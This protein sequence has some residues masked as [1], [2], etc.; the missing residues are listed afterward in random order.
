MTRMRNVVKYMFGAVLALSAFGCES[1]PDSVRTG[2]EVRFSSNGAIIIEQSTRS[3]SPLVAA[4][5][6]QGIMGVMEAGS[7]GTIIK[8]VL[9]PTATNPIRFAVDDS[10]GN[11]TVQQYVDGAYT[12]N[13]SIYRGYDGRVI[14]IGTGLY[15]FVS[16]ARRTASGSEFVPSFDKGLYRFEA[17]GPIDSFQDIIYASVESQIET[18]TIAPTLV[19]LQFHHLWGQIRFEFYDKNTR[20]EASQARLQNVDLLGIR[21]TGELDIITGQI[22]VTSD[23]ALL[24]KAELNQ[25]YFVLPDQQNGREIYALNSAVVTPLKVSYQGKEYFVPID[26]GPTQLTLRSDVCRVVRI[27]TADDTR[28]NHAE[29]GQ[30][31]N[32]TINDEEYE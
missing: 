20:V 8:Q 30:M 2:C 22:S 13:H 26:I 24:D 27:Y 5:G 31:L 14:T 17:S 28:S 7:D 6:W 15:R 32:Y 3:S 1:T 16:L 21:R 12:A 19:E 10:A 9:D 25:T 11:L 4:D 29:M 23:A 18:S